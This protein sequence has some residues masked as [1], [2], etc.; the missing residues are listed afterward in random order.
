MPSTRRR[1][2]Q[3][4][5]TAAALTLFN[6]ARGA[7]AP[8]AVAPTDGTLVQ[9]KPHVSPAKLPRNIPHMVE[10]DG[11]L[12]FDY[13]EERMIL[14]GGLQPFLLCTKAG[15]LIMQAQ[16]PHPP[17]E[18][19]R[20]HYP[21]AMWTTVS[22]DGGKTWTRLPLK[23]G[24]NGLNT[25]GGTIQLRDGTILG[26][27]TYI[28][29]GAKEG[30][31]LGQLY[32]STDE[33][34][35]LTGP[36]EVTFDLPNVN[37]KASKDDGGHPHD[38]QRLHRRMIELPNGDLLTTFYGQLYGDATP[39]T[40]MPLMMKSRVML[41]RSKNRG[42]HWTLVGT[43]AVDHSVGTEGMNEPVLT[44]VSRGPKA[45][46]LICFIRTGRELYEVSSDDE[47][48]TWTKPRPRTFAGLDINRTELWVDMFRAFKGRSGKLLDENNP[49]ELKG[50]VVDPDLIELRSGLLVATFGIR[51][52]QKNCW[53]HAH[54]PWNGNYLAVSRDHGATWTNV[55]R[56]TSGIPTTHYTG[57]EET[58][59]A[60]EIFVVYDYSWWRQPSRFVYGRT[61]KITA[62][63]A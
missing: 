30:S 54:H 3:T 4:A 8:A 34:K 12:R 62:K 44:R 39:S 36:A 33:W 46:R 2:L 47:G 55:V 32:T 50:A 35:T 53:P 52:P 40:Y 49:N 63:S 18:S 48:V 15:T 25:E 51:V 22:R 60:N 16:S 10:A 23:P 17:F 37:F 11:A 6:A 21:Y 9:E 27:D 56:L 14:D 38:A 1:F 31:G 45:G 29:P 24:E 26:L 61:V 19:P 7:N 28:T 20:M 5:A 59:N 57:V 41:V 42:R 43:V 58:P 13:G